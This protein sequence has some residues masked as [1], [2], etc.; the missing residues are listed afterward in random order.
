MAEAD[1]DLTRVSDDVDEVV[2]WITTAWEVDAS[3]AGAE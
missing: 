1:L 2:G 3:E